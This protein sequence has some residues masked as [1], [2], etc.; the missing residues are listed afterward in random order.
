LGKSILF[1]FSQVELSCVVIL[2]TA[3]LHLLL[4]HIVKSWALYKRN[5]SM[6][7]E[8]FCEVLALDMGRQV[9][10][11]NGSLANDLILDILLSL[12]F[13]KLVLL[14]MVS[15]SSLDG[16]NPLWMI[17]FNQSIGHLRFV[18]RLSQYNL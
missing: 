18:N 14:P 6:S 5:G 10:K 8:Y 12:N 17:E 16:L 2:Q 4:D 13:E 7:F 15:E 1:F 3:L 9:V 11:S